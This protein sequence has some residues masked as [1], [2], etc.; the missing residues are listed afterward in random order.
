[1]VADTRSRDGRRLIALAIGLVA[2]GAITSVLVIRRKVLHDEQTYLLSSS[3]N[4][5]ADVPAD[6][7]ISRYFSTPDVQ[8]LLAKASRGDLDGV[9]SMLNLLPRLGTQK[10]KGGVAPLHAALFAQD[11]LAFETLLAAGLDRYL[12]ADNGISPLMAAA[13][14]PNPRFLAAAL[15]GPPPVLNQLDVKGRDALHL[16]VLNR[17]TVNVRL[18]LEK[19]ADPNRK[20]VRGSTPLMAAFQGRRPISNIVNLLLAAGADPAMVD[21]A[22]LNARDFAASFN[23]PA[24]LA[25]TP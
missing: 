24:I 18:L 7:L 21:R 22:G 20:D 5:I 1:M 14:L 6:A 12:P 15:G 13:M 17:Q 8:M 16:A 4:I 19:G 25:M 9:N 3:T 11:T 2:A 10:G 23:D